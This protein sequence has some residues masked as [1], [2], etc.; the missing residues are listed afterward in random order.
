LAAPAWVRVQQAQ[1]R[2]N[3]PIGP[4][5][6]PPGTDG[7]RLVVREVETYPATP[8]EPAP[9]AIPDLTD[10]TVFA[11]VIPIRPPA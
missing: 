10:R 1:G 7:L 8:P 5:A 4:V 9:P 3:T 2:L 11:D 6:I